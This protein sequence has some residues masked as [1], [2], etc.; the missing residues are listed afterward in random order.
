MWAMRD[1]T[2]E[3]LIVDALP[4]DVGSALP[5]IQGL[6]APL[7]P[8]ALAGRKTSMDRFPP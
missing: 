3:V 6:V 2:V 4:F 8:T 7:C 1:A 5:D